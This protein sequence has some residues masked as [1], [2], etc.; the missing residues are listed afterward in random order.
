MGADDLLYEVTGLA[1]GTRHFVRV[2]AVNDVGDGE[3]SAEV[4]FTPATVPGAPQSVVAEPGD[5]SISVTWAA[6]GDGGSA[7][8]AH[9]VQWRAHNGVFVDSDPQVTVGGR[10]Q[11]RRIT[12]LA[13]GIV[14][15][16]RV[17]AANDVGDGPWS[18]PASATPAA[19]RPARTAR[20]CGCG[21][22][23]R[24]GDGHLGRPG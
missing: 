19:P 23:R 5:G 22:G 18:S 13:N 17:M 1:N 9:R 14:Y 21:A 11:S 8:T 20:Q 6:A 10:E 2:L 12:G 4:S 3:P 16:V 15:F 24:F 7:V